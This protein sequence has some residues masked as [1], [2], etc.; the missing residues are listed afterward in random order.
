MEK[1]NK[2][3]RIYNTAKKVLVGAGMVALFGW[4]M[5]RTLNNYIPVSQEDYKNAKWYSSSS[6]PY[7][8]YMNEDIPHNRAT[9]IDYQ[10]AIKEKNG[11]L[12]SATLFPDLD[13]NGKVGE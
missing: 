1:K 5:N 10:G 4:S 9:W 12:E 13:G 8:A 6:L 2:S 3:N 7:N 11:S